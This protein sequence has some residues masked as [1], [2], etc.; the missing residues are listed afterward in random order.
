MQAETPRIF[1]SYAREDSEFALTLAKDLRAAGVTLWLDQLDITPGTRWDRAVEDALKECFCIL[2]ILSPASVSS[3]N[4]MDEVSFGIEEDKKIVPVRH[5]DCDIPFRLKRVQYID[6]TA[7]YATGFAQL[8]KTLTF[9]QPGHT[10]ESS[11][12]PSAP[13]NQGM[14]VPA[15]LLVFGWALGGAL[16]LSIVFNLVGITGG[17]FGAAIGWAIA[18]A[19]GGFFTGLALHKIEPSIRWAQIC[20]FAMGCSVGGA[21]AGALSWSV[22]S[23][24][25]GFI[26]GGIGGSI[27]GLT[28]GYGLQSLKAPIRHIKVSKCVFAWAIGCSLGGAMSWAFLG[29][30][31]TSM[32]YMTV[33]LITGGMV[34]TVAGGLMLWWLSAVIAQR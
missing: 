8:V 23:V 19:I 29:Y 18:G 28:I 13:S 6:F 33:G 32:F 4:V 3:H 34:G 24:I 14:L 27:C 16:G 2:V 21:M 20:M 22:P 25:G 31:Y 1:F 5:L 7:D 30:Q 9:A 26:G 17:P 15:L 11:E 12:P 10:L